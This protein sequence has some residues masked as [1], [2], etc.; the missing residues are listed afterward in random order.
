MFQV[1]QINQKIKPQII[2]LKK[3]ILKRGILILDRGKKSN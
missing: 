1:N 3:D 2:N